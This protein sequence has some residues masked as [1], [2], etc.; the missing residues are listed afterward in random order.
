MYTFFFERLRVLK[1]RQRRGE[2]GFTLIE[3]LVVITILGVLAAVVVFSTQGI[4]DR[5][6]GSSV[7]IDARTLRSAEEAYCSENGIYGTEAQLVADGFLRDFSTYN[8]VTMGSAGSC[9][10]GPNSSFTI[11][12]SAVVPG[13]APEIAIPNNVFAALTDGGINANFSAATGAAAFT[14]NVG[15]N[16]YWTA[17]SPATM[18]SITTGRLR[19]QVVGDG[20]YSPSEPSA[21]VGPLPVDAFFGADR[22][23]VVSTVPNGQPLAGGGTGTCVVGG[24]VDV[25]PGIGSTA[26]PFT[27]GR[28]AVFSCNA[29]WAATGNPGGGATSPRCVAPEIDPL[30]RSSVAQMMDWLDDAPANKLSIAIPAS[31]PFGV[32]SRQAMINAGFPYNDT[33]GDP[34]R[35]AYPPGAGA[36][37]CEGAVTGLPCKIRLEPGVTQ[38]RQAVTQGTGGVRAGIMALSSVKRVSWTSG[39]AGPDGMAGTGDDLAVPSDDPNFWTAVATSE[40]NPIEQW[41]VAIDTVT[42][43]ERKTAARAFIDWLRNSSSQAILATYGYE[44]L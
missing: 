44:P 4:S 8:E 17:A 6:E 37:Q 12:D 9:G 32:A 1:R 20:P 15:T 35:N 19:Q 7:A 14:T 21:E 26:R 31:A 3:L 39:T 23:T 43:D 30:K 34:N 16:G 22:A 38:V 36:D 25:C 33:V 29:A 10:T 42:T 40:H 18:Q 2:A 13:A 24:I 5:G 27:I 41:A 11:A 28:L